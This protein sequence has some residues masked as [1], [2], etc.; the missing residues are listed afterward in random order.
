MHK[1]RDL[2]VGISIDDFG[3]SYFSL[4][5]LTTLPITQLKIDRT[6]MQALDSNHQAIVKTIITLAKNLN[7]TV[8]AE[9]VETTEQERFLQ[10]LQCD[11]V[12]GYLYFKPL[13]KEQIE[14]LLQKN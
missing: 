12:Q 3:T 9:G 6:F 5:C 13:P 7:L 8:V 2:G 1:L 10:E 14:T 11:E 4:S